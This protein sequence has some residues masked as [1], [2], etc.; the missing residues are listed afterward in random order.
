VPV[1]ERLHAVRRI[2][3]HTF[4]TSD[5]ELAILSRRLMSHPPFLKVRISFRRLVIRTVCVA[6]RNFL[7][8]LRPIPAHFTAPQ[9]T[10]CL[11]ELWDQSN[12]AVYCDHF[13]TVTTLLLGRPRYRG[14]F[15]LFARGFTHRNVPICS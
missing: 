2:V 5:F 3:D 15:Q 11:L 13:R 10:V 14:R 9:G 4:A 7:I 8:N 6:V 12:D 1:H